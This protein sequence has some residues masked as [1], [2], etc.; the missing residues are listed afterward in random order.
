MIIRPNGRAR[1]R[2]VPRA[3]SRGRGERVKFAD[4]IYKIAD[5]IYKF[6]DEIHEFADENTKLPTITT[7]KFADK[8]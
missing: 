1:P 5:E 7:Y 4:G 2:D 8:H 3:F 6:A